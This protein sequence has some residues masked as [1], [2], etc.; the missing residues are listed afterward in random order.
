M[1][2]GNINDAEK[3]Y[4]VNPHLK[5]AFE[6]LKKFTPYSCENYKSDNV[7]IMVS[8]NVTSDVSEDGILNDFESHRKYLDIHFVID[9][10]EAIGYSNVKYLKEKTQYNTKDDYQLFEGF[11][12][13]IRL[14][15]G[16]FCIVF[17]EDA[18]IPCMVADAV[19]KVKRCVV[20]IKV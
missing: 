15:K 17:P 12:N 19:S 16:D 18:H 4:S 7:T 9:G 2:V 10:V 14:E 5:E 11:I 8:D 3:Y 1:I 6:V 20:K 13:K